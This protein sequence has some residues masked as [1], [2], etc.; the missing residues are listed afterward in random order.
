M[1]LFDAA[2]RED[3][4]HPLACSYLCRRRIVRNLDTDTQLWKP[5]FKKIR[6]LNLYLKILITPFLRHLDLLLPCGRDRF[7]TLDLSINKQISEPIT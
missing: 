5:L 2:M 6:N 7:T 4:T 1:G 3:W